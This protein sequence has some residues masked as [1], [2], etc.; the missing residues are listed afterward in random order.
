MVWKN[1]FSIG[2]RSERWR[3]ERPLSP[4][5]IWPGSRWSLALDDTWPERPLAN[6]VSGI[7]LSGEVAENEYLIAGAP[8][9]AEQ[10]ARQWAIGGAG[11]DGIQIAL[12]R[13]LVVFT[14]SAA[15]SAMFLARPK[16]RSNPPK[17]CTRER[18]YSSVQVHSAL[19]LLGLYGTSCKL[20][21][22]P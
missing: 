11:K 4:Q 17:V 1:C 19:Q 13:A 8:D 15:R 20:L 16:A 2:A 22:A 12:Q 3:A 6:F 7:D 5:P 10:G 18:C 14:L 9:L 21:P